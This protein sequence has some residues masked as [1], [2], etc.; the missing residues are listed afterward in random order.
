MKSF[1]VVIVPT[2]DSTVEDIC[3]KSSPRE[4]GYHFLGGMK[5]EEVVGFYDN[6][7]TAKNLAAMLI[8]HPETVP[9]YFQGPA[10]PNP[11]HN[12]GRAT[13]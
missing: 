10:K 12:D 2:P 6:E 9:A 7:R 13:A 1:W 5:P 8:E 4:I 3:F 11:W